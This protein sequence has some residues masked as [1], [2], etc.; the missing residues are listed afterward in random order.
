M[1]NE[2]IFI[3]DFYYVNRSKRKKEKILR[4][5]NGE[6]KIG[7]RGD[8]IKLDELERKLLDRATSC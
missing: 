3:R 7:K 6:G 8:E 1:N 4:Y 5:R 2:Q